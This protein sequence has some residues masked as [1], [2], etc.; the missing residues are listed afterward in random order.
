MAGLSIAAA[1]A[2]AVAA[3]VDRSTALR[4]AAAATGACMPLR[5]LA[6]CGNPFPPFAYSLPW[7]EFEASSYEV[8]IVGDLRAEVDKGLR[9]LLAVASPGL[10]YEYLEN[11]EA[12]TVSQRRVGFVALPPAGESVPGLAEDLVA[13][14]GSLDAKR[15]VH[16]LAH[17]L[18]A[19]VALSAAASAPAGTIASLIISSPVGCG[20]DVAP[21]ARDALSKSLLYTTATRGR[22]CVDATAGTSAQPP[23]RLLARL[24][25]DLNGGGEAASGGGMEGGDGGRESDGGLSPVAELAAAAPPIPLLLTRGAAGDV[26]S[27]AA[28]RATLAAAR[29]RGDGG[30]FVR[31][32]S[33]AGSVPLPF[34]DAPAAFGTAVL[35]FC[36]GVDG[37][38]TRRVVVAGGDQRVTGKI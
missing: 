10:S 19:P 16:L 1:V 30:S 33:F 27:E 13:A 21:A 3:A 24:Q 31:E 25:R 28:V 38:R 23:A 34:V 6:W 2:S 15:G 14:I 11:L 22:A 29:A 4:L 9:P 7:F 18:A 17:G 32:A 20:A 37:V 36:D 8:R 35:D 26:S 12:L 5:A